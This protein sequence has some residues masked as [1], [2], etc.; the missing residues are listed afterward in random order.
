[1]RK[2]NKGKC[3]GLMGKVKSE[4]EAKLAAGR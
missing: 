2:V 4:A 3:K 1:L